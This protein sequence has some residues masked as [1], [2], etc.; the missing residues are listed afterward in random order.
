MS[1]A[2]NFF[3][4]WR[5]RLGYPL[6]IAVLYLS[7]PTPRSIFLG[8]MVGVIG[9][10]L[11]AYAAGYLHKQ[12]VLTVTGPYA[13]T[14]NPLYLG[15]AILALGAGIATRSWLSGL[16]LIVYFAV[17]Y[18]IVMRREASELRLRHGTSFDEY[19]RTVPLFIPRLTAAKL[20]GDSAGSFS[21]AQYKKNHEWQAAV[22]FLFLLL[23]LLA[24]WRFP[25][26]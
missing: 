26:H 12:E 22:G 17:F 24:I 16:I 2:G 11:R 20:P 18:S 25:L 10:W 4:R 19:A 23:V 15:S 14:R 6:A 8:A 13:Y 1:A 7:R 21:F 3:V 5:V 9:L